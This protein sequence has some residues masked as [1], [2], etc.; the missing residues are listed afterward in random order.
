[1][2]SGTL[3][4]RIGQVG[5]EGVK[6]IADETTG[7]PASSC[8]PRKGVLFSSGELS[9]VERAS[10]ELIEAVGSRRAI[11]WAGERT[12]SL[13]YLDYKRAETAPLG[14]EDIIL[15]GNPGKA[16]VL[17]DF[18]HGTQQRLGIIDRLG[19]EGAEHHVKDFM[20][21]HRRLLGLGDEDVEIL[22]KLMELGL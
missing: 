2:S 13:R 19:R 22:R 11:T 1:M 12:E 6:T 15:R 3:L 21:R 9:S 7:L 4:Q 17:E 5:K 14:A 10:A 20:I 16:A 8:S 18:L